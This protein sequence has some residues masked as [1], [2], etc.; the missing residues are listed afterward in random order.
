MIKLT[1][2]FLTLL[3]SFYVG[4]QESL[5]E[6]RIT[7]HFDPG[8]GST[9]FWNY[10]SYPQTKPWFTFSTGINYERTFNSKHGIIVGVDASSIGGQSYFVSSETPNVDSSNI[11]SSQSKY[12]EYLIEVPLS[13]V[14]SKDY[15]VLRLSGIFGLINSFGI[16]EGYKSESTR[17]NGQISYKK[18]RSYSMG[19][20][21]NYYLDMKI[22]ARFLFKVNE[23]VSLG[24][25]PYGRINVFFPGGTNFFLHHWNAHIAFSFSYDF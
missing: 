13:Y 11:H 19:D 14:I 10:K 22:G 15:G 4:S 6:H 23:N 20:F 7:I 9:S 25:E 18:W 12:H 8:V 21:F 1:F 17:Y 2:L 16:A 3:F 5:S 24:I